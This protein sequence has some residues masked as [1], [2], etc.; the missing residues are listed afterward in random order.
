MI[1][2]IRSEERGAAA[3]EF[4]LVAPVFILFI[5]GIA[6]LGILFFAN[7]AVHSALADGAR[8]ASMFP[9]PT[10]EAIRTEISAQRFGLDSDHLDTPEIVHG[11][12][13]GTTFADIT[14]SYTVQLDFIFF[15]TDAVTLTESRRVFTQP[16]AA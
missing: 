3:L 14:L 10:D 7:A 5:I 6:Q 2:G 11:A 4:A 15:Q 8:A 13:G 12:S 9:L 1:R 16:A